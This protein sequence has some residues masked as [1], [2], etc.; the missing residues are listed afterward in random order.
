MLAGLFVRL[1]R[2]DPDKLL[3]DV[4]H[5]DVIHV[6]GGE[7]YRSECLHDFVEK[8]FLRHLGDL[9]VKGEALHDRPNIGREAIN[10]G[11]EVGRKLVRVIEQFGQVELRKI[12]KGVFS[13][14][15][16]E[17]PD[18]RLRL[19]FDFRVFGKH[20]CLGGGEEAIKAA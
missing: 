2:A 19:I 1:L 9:L 13:D 6:L 15:L 17:A 10:V 5:L 3:E 12:V 18:N 16:K 14:F 7:I 4:S 20:P 11:V 8:V